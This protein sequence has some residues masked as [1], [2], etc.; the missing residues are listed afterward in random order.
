MTDSSDLPPQSAPSEQVEADGNAS[1]RPNGAI[2][3]GLVNGRYQLQ[4]LIGTTNLGTDY[5]A[6]DVLLDRDVVFKA[7]H[8][9]L[10]G[11]RGFIER[12]RA[13]AQSTANLTHPAL[14]SVLDWGRDP[15]GLDTLPGPLYYLVSERVAGR[16]VRELI[17]L[18][19]PMPVSRVLHVLIGVTSALSYA[20][21]A[22]ALH[23]GLSPDS[24][25]VSPTGV[26]KVADLGLGLALGPAW[27]PAQ[28][29]TDIALWRTPEQF[30][31]APVDARSDVYQVGLLAYFLST[32]RAPF[33]GETVEQISQRHLEVIPPAPTKLNTKLPKQVEGIIG[34]S[35]A[36]KPEERYQSIND[37]RSALVRYRESR[38]PS[39]SGDE[40][41]ALG[42]VANG[43][44]LAEARSG[45]THTTSSNQSRN[46]SGNA[47]DAR[48]TND[49]Q[50][51]AAAGGEATSLLIADETRV[52]AT[53]TSTNDNQ[54]DGAASRLGA[55]ADPDDEKGVLGTPEGSMA[56]ID[57]PKRKRSGPVA[58]L[59]MVLLAILGVLLWFLGQQLGLFG[60]AKPSI[61]VPSVKSLTSGEAEQTLAAAGLVPETQNEPNSQVPADIV[62]EQLPE[63][64]TKVAK[65]SKVR[66]RV[67]TGVGKPIVPMVVGDTIDQ[68]TTKLLQL[69]FAIKTVEEINDSVAPGTVTS[70]SPIAKTEAESGAIVTVKVATISGTVEVPD[71]ANLTADEAKLVLTKALFRTS[72]NVE[73]SQAIEKGK[74]IRTEPPAG[75]KAERG[76][77]VVIFRSGGLAIKV[78]QLQGLTQQEAETKVASEAPGL[79]LDITTRIVVDPTEVGTVIAQSPAAAADADP[80]S[81][82]SIRVGIPDDRPVATK[83]P[84]VTE[85]PTTIAP[86]ASG[87]ASVE[88]TVATSISTTPDTQPP[89]AATTAPAPPVEQP[90]PAPAPETAVVRTVP[91][92]EAPAPQPA[93]VQVTP[94]P[95]PSVVP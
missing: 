36:K 81:T 34:R 48:G 90:A 59:I 10:V 11:D 25:Y 4:S 89:A 20:H 44:S 82:I 9:H 27:Q 57:S 95:N 94:N 72:V 84:V 71:V 63:A 54:K 5:V 40:T 35:L 73:A 8:G 78:P 75:T 29:Q 70:Q 7:L 17:D 61:L 23:G 79:K 67:S 45:Q 21:R 39:P 88:A 87:S 30:R 51:G 22:D 24:V 2:P 66:I 1:A 37:Q 50:S 68:A 91:P 83:K 69:G 93:P 41:S 56:D 65:E 55:I 52:R 47:H 42:S 86:S 16:T 6:R 18:N 80:G 43:T 60:E 62:F 32:G 31:G 3:D 49:H 26:V 76:S 92:T 74:V 46:Q 12:F 53:T 64:G 15:N 77:A 28:D 13:Q 58:F 19:G 33:P 38:N 14:A 85:A